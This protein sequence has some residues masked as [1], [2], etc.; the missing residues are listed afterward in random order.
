[1]VINEFNQI[2]YPK[3]MVIF[4]A[5]DF[6]K[7]MYLYLSRESDFLV[8]AFCVDDPYVNDETL[9]GLPVVAFSELYSRFPADEYSGVIAIGYS[10]IRLRQYFFDRVKSL[11]YGLVNFFHP[12]SKVDESIVL[13]EGNIFFP[14]VVVEPGCI[15]GDNNIFWSSVNICH[16]STVGSGNFFAAQASIGGFSTV[17]DKCFFGFSSTI[18]QCLTVGNEVLIGANSLILNDLDSF[19]RYYGSPA[20]FISNHKEDGICIK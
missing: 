13:G 18:S 7:L 5:S 20:K 8:C 4:G 15:V 6:A 19:G 9:C 3:K 1:M 17:K 14:N 12:D 16:D 2:S 11:G 10:S